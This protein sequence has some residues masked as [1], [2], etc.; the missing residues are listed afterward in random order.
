MQFRGKDNSII[1]Q[2]LIYRI[3]GYSLT[4]IAGILHLSK[5]RI[6]QIIQENKDEPGFKKYY[7]EMEKT[8]R[9]LHRKLDF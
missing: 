9:L 4:S 2:I 5:Q 8:N 1:K 7:I 3:R 6:A